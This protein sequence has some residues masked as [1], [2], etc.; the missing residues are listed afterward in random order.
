[1]DIQ[2]KIFPQK[3][4]DAGEIKYIGDIN[5]KPRY[6]YDFEDK[7]Y[8][9]VCLKRQYEEV[10]NLG[11]SPIVREI[12]EKYENMRK[13]YFLSKWV[14]DWECGFRPK[15]NSE[16][17]AKYMGVKPFVPSVMINISPNW[18]NAFGKDKLTDKLMIKNFRKVVE[19]YL[20]ASNR[21]SRYKYCLECGSEGNHL[22]AHIVAEFRKSCIK[23]VQTH[24]NKGNHAIELRKIWDKVFPKGYV[25]YLKGKYAIQ[26]IIL[27]V[28]TLRDDKLKYL[29]E[30]EKPEGH[31]NKTDLGILVNSGF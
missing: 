25:G 10:D 22:H 23:S 27:R 24:I 9:G 15:H 13:D 31:T 21:Y 14:D 12:H 5:M 20:N 29:I 16:S 11:L 6:I 1:M 4:L 2:L 8:E 17:I 3:V 19:T 30:N 26:R 28:E 7:V 18:K